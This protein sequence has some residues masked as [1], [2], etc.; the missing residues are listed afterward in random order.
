M[1]ASANQPIRPA[2]PAEALR[3]AVD[4][5]GS[6]AAMARLLRVKQPSVWAWLARGKELPPEH[7][8]AVEAATGVSKHDLRPDIYPH[9][10]TAAARD[11][12]EPAR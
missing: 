1:T 12:M 2:T 5:I 4:L 11:T 10:D 6:Q 9:E 8:L 3:L 7:V